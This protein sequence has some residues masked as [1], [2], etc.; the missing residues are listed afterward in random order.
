M[1]DRSQFVEYQV[2]DFPEPLQV[3]PLPSEK[4][5]D[6]RLGDAEPACHLG[7]VDQVPPRLG[8]WLSVS[9]FSI[10]KDTQGK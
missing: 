9:H 7:T 4:H 3:L 8:F 6:V 5:I 1:V 10:V 2:L